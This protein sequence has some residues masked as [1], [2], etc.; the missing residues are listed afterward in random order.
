MTEIAEWKTKTKAEAEALLKA[1]TERIQAAEA[2]LKIDKADKPAVEA[3]LAALDKM[4][5]QEPYQCR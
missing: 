4:T 3:V 1:I 5:D 2:Q